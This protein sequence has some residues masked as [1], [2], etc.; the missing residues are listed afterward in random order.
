MRLNVCFNE[1]APFGPFA[2]VIRAQKEVC[3]RDEMAESPGT[4]VF[5]IERYEFRR[6]FRVFEYTVWCVVGSGE[7]FSK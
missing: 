3:P 1:M 5:P 6:E 2:A 7:I 4:S